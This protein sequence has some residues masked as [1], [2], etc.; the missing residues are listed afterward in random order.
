M[1]IGTEEYERTAKSIA[2]LNKILSDHRKAIRATSEEAKTF[3]SV[4]GKGADFINKW[5]YSAQSALQLFVK[6]QNVARQYVEDYAR[7][8]GN[9]QVSPTRKSIR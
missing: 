3:G 8:E 2:D 1:T 5:Y 9:T 6:V 7:M 4:L